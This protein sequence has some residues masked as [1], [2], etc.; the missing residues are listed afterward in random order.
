MLDIESRY[1]RDF[2]VKRTLAQDLTGFSGTDKEFR[3]LITELNKK[4]NSSDSEDLTAELSKEQSSSN[5]EDLTAEPTKKGSGSHNIYSPHDIR[6]ARKH[7]LGIEKKR[8]T[9]ELPP[10][11]VFHM[12]KGGVGKTTLAVNV[13]A[14]L[15]LYGYKT[16]MIDGDPQG[17]ASE[18]LGV[19]TADE[20]LV[21]IGH[22]MSAHIQAKKN[23]TQEMAIRESICN[24][25]PN[26]MLDLIPADITL[27]AATL[28]MVQATRRE[29][30]FRSFLES[31]KNF[32]SQYDAIVVDTAPS[33]SA[34]TQT[35]LDAAKN[36]IIAP[37]TLDG[38][39]I[40]AVRVLANI[41]GEL[42]SG[43]KLNALRPL[44]I[45]NA[46]RNTNAFSTL[47]LEKVASEF[48]EYIA[49]II[50]SFSPFFPKQ[51]DISEKEE[52]EE[53]NL[54]ALEREHGKHVARNLLD[55]AAFLIR[56]FDIRLANHVD[57]RFRATA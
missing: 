23:T 33:T 11:L 31:N 36:T 32:F 39:S 49:E 5:S 19:N 15:S 56:Q 28:W 21:H 45:A 14:G 20:K 51:F 9:L 8:D 37:V 54:P 18:L 38:Q 50:V 43:R 4:Y 34:L 44:I 57:A 17:T 47:A 26:G 10:L 53:V 12:T 55:L 40:K 30:I 42:N 27:A 6:L 13:A 29:Q 16:L 1:P 48:K 46:Y 41:L 7:L 24:I 25:Y 52:D 22:L 35:F 3:N 2:R